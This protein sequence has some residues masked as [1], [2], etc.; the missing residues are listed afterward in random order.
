M[1]YEAMPGGE[2]YLLRPCLSVPPLCQYAWLKDG[3]IDLVDLAIMHDALDVR[4]ENQRR[5]D[6]TQRGD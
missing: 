6:A 2:D 4:A 5:F 1:K 3:T